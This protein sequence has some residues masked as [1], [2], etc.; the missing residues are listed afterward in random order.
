MSK[1]AKNTNKHNKSTNIKDG[2]NRD[3]G[4]NFDESIN[5]KE[6][7]Q[8]AGKI[9]LKSNMSN[10]LKNV[11]DVVSKFQ[12]K[13]EIN[14][15]ELLSKTNIKNTE[16]DLETTAKFNNTKNK[17]SEP[18]NHDVKLGAKKENIVNKSNS[19]NKVQSKDNKKQN[20]NLKS[21]DKKNESIPVINNNIQ[22][23]QDKTIEE[24]VVKPVLSQDDIAKDIDNFIQTIENS[25]IQSKISLTRHLRPLLKRG[26]ELGFVTYEEIA[27]E[28]PT[29]TTA[30]MYD[31]MIAM[32]NEAGIDVM[33]DAED[34]NKIKP[35]ATKP[36]SQDEPNLVEDSLKMY[37]KQIGSP[38]LLNKDQEVE[39][40]KQIEHGNKMVLFYICNSAIGMNELISVYDDL[41]TSKVQMREVIDIDG[42]Y[43]EEYGSSVIED[44][45]G[46]A[47]NSNEIMQNR[48]SY[49]RSRS[50]EYGDGEMGDVDE[51]LDELYDENVIS[52]SAMEIALRPK[53][54]EILNDI[55][56]LCLKML[57]IQKDELYGN[58]VDQ[59]KYD[60]MRDTL[61]EKVVAIKL[62]QNVINL[63]VKKRDEI[64][65]KLV[66]LEANLISL[67]EKA[68]IPRREFIEFYSG[69]EID[70]TWLENAP[71]KTNWKLLVDKFGDEVVT[72]KKE[73]EI[74]VKKSIVTKV[75][76]F[77]ENIIAMQRHRRET[78]AA[79]TKMIQA[80]LRLVISIVKRYT[81]RGIPLID[82]IQEGN[83]GLMRAVDKFDYK[84]GHKFSTYA[85]WWIKQATNRAIADQ[86]RTIRIPVHVLELV[87][88]INKTIRDMSKKLGREPTQKELSEELVIPIEKIRKV[89]RIAKDPISLDSPIGD[90]DMRHIDV[91]QDVN[92]VSPVDATEAIILNKISTE[93]LATLTP[94]EERV[95]RERFGISMNVDKTLEEVGKNFGVTR[96]RIRQIEAKALR[97]LR[98][99][100]RSQKLRSFLDIKL[101]DY[102]HLDQDKNEDKAEDAEV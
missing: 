77:K 67:A 11:S 59:K 89:M 48:I 76:K 23:N 99:P 34:L 20:K 28:M 54:M 37:M 10:A 26:K 36:Q 79:K 25:T 96:E 50:A 29:K 72:I 3:S 56:D 31:D 83:I 80:N 19:K 35:V 71:K 85:T 58:E 12:N 86:A 92:A 97:K 1:N 40:A 51:D 91:V 6:R 74:L 21:N 43:T 53:V 24:N 88:K 17:I 66:K 49:L 60:A 22:Q 78:Q 68:G 45:E 82:L 75:A 63:I 73:I 62:H 16:K 93:I 8:Q 42:L 7:S 81:N 47:L 95:L 46:N 70:D 57:R 84:R 65:G 41:N 52:F 87:G 101:D 94:R 61:F 39:I 2:K 102:K 27:E 15:N 32:L 44:E 90:G 69:K 33:G 9:T 100:A 38:V 4:K 55:T 18:K 14:K 64:H 98:H 30:E 5:W 13:N